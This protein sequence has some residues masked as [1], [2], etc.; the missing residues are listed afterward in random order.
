MTSYTGMNFICDDEGVIGLT[1]EHPDDRE[2]LV[3]E[4]E[5]V[6]ARWPHEAIRPCKLV[7]SDFAP[8]VNMAVH[9]VCRFCFEKDLSY[10]LHMKEVSVNIDFDDP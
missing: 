3:C 9:D 2:E 4:V 10:G 7:Y 6:C 8:L 5:H 1:F